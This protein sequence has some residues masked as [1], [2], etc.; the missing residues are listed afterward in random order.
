MCE[1]REKFLSMNTEIEDLEK[2]IGLEEQEHQNL[3]QKYEEIVSQLQQEK[4]NMSYKIV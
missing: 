4:V 2:K 1:T 3:L